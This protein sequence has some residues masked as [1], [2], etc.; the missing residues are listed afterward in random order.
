MRSAVVVL[1]LAACGAS[2]P[3]CVTAPVARGAPFL[4]KVSREG[5]A[6][7]W[8]FG[9]VHNGT[10]AS[11]PAAAWAALDASPRFASEL[12]DLEPDPDA[13]RDVTMLPRGKG[14]DQQLPADDWYDL[15]DALR[16]VMKEADLAR[17]RPWYAMSKLSVTVAPP[18]DPT[19]DVAI[20]A[21]AK[22]RGLAIEHLETWE[23]QLAALGDSVTIPDLQDAIHARKTMACDLARIR[24]LYESG[25]A[26]AITP[27]L[28]TPGSARLLVERNRAWIPQVEALA[29]DRGGFIAV[30]LGHMLGDEGLV[31]RLA[32][33]GYAVERQ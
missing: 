33:A 20:A 18:P 5:A 10:R 1:L 6:T 3:P 14:L 29:A 8:L 11:V 4:W 30:G 22:E 19:M 23:A 31:A 26:V 15:R 2:S 7:V 12:G 9:T 28:I 16:G 25:D 17:V 27:I 32:A 13:L 21:R 24:A